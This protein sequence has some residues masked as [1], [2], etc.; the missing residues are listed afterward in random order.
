MH[1]TTIASGS[2]GNAILV[3]EAKRHL[4]VDCGISGARF[5][6]NLSCLNIAS[7]E[8]EGIIVTHEHVD[9]IRGVGILARKL[10]IPVY[11]TAGLW[12]VMRPALG[13]LGEDQ[14][15]SVEQSFSCAGLNVVLYPTSHDSRESYGLKI[16]RPAGR[17]KREM[18]VGIATDSG[19]VTEA[20]HCHL[21]GCDALVAEANYDEQMLQTGPYP[22]YL[23]RRIRGQYGHLENSQLAEGLLAWLDEK[24]QRVL[25]AHLSEENNRPQVAFSTVRRILRDSPRAKSFK[26]VFLQVAP[27]HSPHELIMLKE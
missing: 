18:S 19:I 7:E 11:A 5:L 27:R 13:K 12:E 16:S 4:L 20:M 15:R 22:A 23:K 14:Q 24:T 6:H 3:G 8:I 1:F 2:S 10:K 21:Q 9:H 17:D 25:L 26:N